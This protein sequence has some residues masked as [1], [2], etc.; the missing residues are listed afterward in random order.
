MPR[1]F[2]QF[3]EVL[4]S[5][6]WR[7]FFNGIIVI[8][9]TAPRILPQGLHGPYHAGRSIP[10]GARKIWGTKLCL[11]LCQRRV[12]RHIAKVGTRVQHKR[13]QANKKTVSSW[14]ME[15]NSHEYFIP[16]VITT[17]EYASKGFPL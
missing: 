16:G 1:A 17:H 7:N 15:T 3:F 2:I 11:Y 10:R 14:S 9:I 6:Q 8:Y 5:Q 12:F 4:G 13:Q